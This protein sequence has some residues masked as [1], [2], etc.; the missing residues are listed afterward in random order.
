MLV[1]LVGVVL[2][3]LTVLL[4]IEL[5][6]IVLSLSLGFVTVPG[7]STLG[8]GQLVGLSS[9]DAS[10]HLLGRMMANRLACMMSALPL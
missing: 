6:G 7:I 2:V 3:I 5:F 8:L 10:E 9:G 4:V 1:L